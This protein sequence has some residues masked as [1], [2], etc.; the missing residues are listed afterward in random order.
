M[1]NNIKFIDLPL[2]YN[3]IK[4]D[5]IKSFNIIH[6]NADYINGYEVLKF[7]KKLKNF[8]N[9]KHVISC[10]N[11]TDAL[12]IAILSLNL[13]PKD[14]VILP[15]FT[16]VSVIEVVCLLNLVPVLVDV[17]LSTFN[18]DPKQ[19]EKA[20]SPKT[21]LIIPVHLFGH[22]ADMEEIIKIAKKNRIYIIEDAA[23]SFNSS[24][25]FSDKKKYKSGTVGDIGCFSFFPTKNFSCYG[26]GGAIITNSNA[27]AK[28]IRMIKNHGQLKKNVHEILGINSRLDTLQAAV[29]NIKLKYLKNENLKRKKNASIY[30]KKLALIKDIVLPSKYFFSDHIYHQYTI[31]VNKR[32]RDLLK[33]KLSI[34]NIPTFIYYPLPLHLQKAYRKSIKKTGPLYISSKLCKEVL[35]LPIHPWLSNNQINYISK[36]IKEIL[37]G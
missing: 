32:K 33:K 1:S 20:L 25:I 12:K 37:D 10:G 15:A 21:K 31:R 6:K 23:Q 2:Q 4:K 36:S 16:Y 34:K 22:N 3:K 29:L 17:D 8:L 11:C 28:K 13:K 5:V 30:N 26:D 35:S 24:L 19:I 14:E 27:L 18:L 9:V 7:E